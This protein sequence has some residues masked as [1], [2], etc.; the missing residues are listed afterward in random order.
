MA[1]LAE[2][3]VGV[4]ALRHR[5][6]PCWYQPKNVA[7]RPLVYHAPNNIPSWARNPQRGWNWTANVA[8]WVENQRLWPNSIGEGRA[9]KPKNVTGVGALT[10]FFSFNA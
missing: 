5:I 2:P 6:V 1:Q 3:G 10:M 9:V 4:I 7:L 8:G